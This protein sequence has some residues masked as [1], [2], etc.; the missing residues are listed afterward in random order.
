MY[1]KTLLLFILIIP[2]IVTSCS[3]KRSVPN[4]HDST[5][6]SIGKQVWMKKN[7]DVDH[8]RNGDPIPMVSDPDKWAKLATGAWCFIGNDSAMG[9][10]YG[11]LYN[12][13]AVNDP[14]GLAPPG[15]HVASDKEWIE[16]SNYLGKDDLAGGKLKEA[17]T[18]HWKSPNTGGTNAS[19]F[20]ALPGG[21]RYYLRTDIQIGIYGYWWTSTQIDISNAWSRSLEYDDDHLM[22][23]VGYKLDGLSVRCVRD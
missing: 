4:L 1:F 11:K 3:D 23:N 14:R 18:T 21:W 13:Y 7:L 6:V 8:Y 20:T 10:I 17:G 16:L 12:W 19:G 22:S 15:W 2:I 9:A 5:T